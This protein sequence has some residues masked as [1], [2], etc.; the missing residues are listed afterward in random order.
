MTKSLDYSPPI[1]FHVDSQPSDARAHTLDM[2]IVEIKSHL[3]IVCYQL[4]EDT[5]SR[6]CAYYGLREESITLHSNKVT[7]LIQ[8]GS[9]EC[10]YNVLHT[11]HALTGD[12]CAILQGLT[13]S[14]KALNLC[15]CGIYKGFDASV[16]R[17]N[18]AAQ[19][20][21]ESRDQR[22]QWLNPPASHDSTTWLPCQILQR[23]DCDTNGVWYCVN[24]RIIT[25]DVTM[26]CQ[27]PDN[28]DCLFWKHTD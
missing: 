4:I 28:N 14:A 10:G 23:L 27:L 12:N 13:H 20:M 15:S 11:I 18:M 8:A 6:N 1:F 3:K 26:W 7:S 2:L 25:N 9:W 21:K 24:F 17:D 5:L 22:P 16:M 19:A